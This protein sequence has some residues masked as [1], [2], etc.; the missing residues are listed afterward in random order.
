MQGTSQNEQNKGTFNK[1]ILAQFVYFCTVFEIII[2][3]INY[4]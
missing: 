3:F 1:R 4:E 2:L